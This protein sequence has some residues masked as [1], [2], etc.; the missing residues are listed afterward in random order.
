MNHSPAYTKQELENYKS[1]LG[2]DL[3][4]AVLVKID[5]ER[6]TAAILPASLAINLGSLWT[7]LGTNKIRLLDKKEFKSLF[8]DYEFGTFP[9]FGKLYNMDTFLAKELESCQEIKFYIG[10]Y[11]NLVQMKYEDFAKLVDYRQDA[12]FLSKTRYRVFVSHIAPESARQKLKDQEHC[13]LGVSLE[14]KDFSTAKLFS[15]VDWIS[16]HFKKCTVLVGDSLHRI[17]LQIDQGLSENQ[18]LNNAL[19]LGREYVNRESNV[20]ECYSDAC[21]FNFIFCSEIQETEDY[22]RYYE[23]LSSLFRSDEQFA[24]SIKSFARTYILRRFAENSE[25]FERYVEMSCAYLLEELAIFACLAQ[26]DLSIMVYPGSLAIF[27]E[28]SEG[29]HPKVP[30]CLKKIIHVSLRFKKR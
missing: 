12:V 4:E 1:T 3:I 21:S 27:E 7:A 5:D 24:N 16:K 10:S 11:T 23:Q 8:P 2:M 15:I 26:Y 6:I 9:P 22:V 29:Q 20:F 18:A 14:N 19:I 25:S 13:F 17:T 28:I 30:D